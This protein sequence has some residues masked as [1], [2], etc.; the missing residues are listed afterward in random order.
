MVSVSF[1]DKLVVH[2]SVVGREGPYVLARGVDAG[3][4]N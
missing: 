3:R 4:G 1:V 2:E